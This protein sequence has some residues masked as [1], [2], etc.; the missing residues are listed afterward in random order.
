MIVCCLLFVVCCLLFVVFV[1]LTSCLYLFLYLFFLAQGANACNHNHALDHLVKYYIDKFP[2]K[3]IRF[4]IT[5]DGCRGQYAGRK[6]FAKMASFSARHGGIE[7]THS[8]QTVFGGKG[9]WDGLGKQ[10][11]RQITDAVAEVKFVVNFTIEAAI[12]GAMRARTPKKAPYGPR[13]EEKTTT[14]IDEKKKAGTS[15]VCIVIC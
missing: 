9:V 11:K 7:I 1:V 5:T 3:T 4:I 2:G 6:N 13:G 14:P 8:I 12:V 15:F 10:I